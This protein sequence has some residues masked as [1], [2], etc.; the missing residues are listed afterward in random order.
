MNKK[1]LF[2]CGAFLV[3]FPLVLFALMYTPPPT[4]TIPDQRISMAELAEKDGLENRECWVAIDGTVY[5]ISGFSQWQMG[6]HLP[7]QGKATCGRDLSG[8][9]GESPHGKSVLSLLRT[10]GTLEES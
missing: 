6:R 4:Q 9:I 5:S 1:I 8:V 3:G 7:S 2:V 10:V